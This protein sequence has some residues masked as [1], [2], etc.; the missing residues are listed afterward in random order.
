MLT[1][2]LLEQQQLE[3]GLWLTG[4]QGHPCMGR[5]A[6]W[7]CEMTGI[8]STTEQ[9]STQLCMVSLVAGLQLAWLQVSGSVL[10]ESVCVNPMQAEY[11]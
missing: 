4:C 11:A 6:L 3:E 2:E 8:T 10:L 7:R 5:R 1:L 9:S